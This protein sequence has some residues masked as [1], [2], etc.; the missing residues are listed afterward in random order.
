MRLFPIPSHVQIQVTHG[1]VQDFF[2]GEPLP[3]VIPVADGTLCH[4]L[5]NS[6]EGI[7]RDQVTPDGD[8]GSLCSVWVHADTIFTSSC[9][10]DRLMVRSQGP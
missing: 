3:V 10:C 1:M 9:N 8:G 2:R 4:C 7:G 5:A 6:H